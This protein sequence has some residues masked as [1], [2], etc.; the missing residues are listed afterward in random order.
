M[1]GLKPFHR[2]EQALA[3]DHGDDQHVLFLDTV[4]HAVAVDET[5]PMCGGEFG[6]LASAHGELG[7]AATRGG[8]LLDDFLCVDIL[9]FFKWANRSGTVYASVEIKKTARE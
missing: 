5:F 7:E 4:D 9:E 8:Q 2:F 6:H 3:V 1:S